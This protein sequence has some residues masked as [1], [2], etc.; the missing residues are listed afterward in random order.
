M[1][2]EVVTALVGLASALFGAGGGITAY[3][4]LRELGD[5]KEASEIE[6]LRDDVRRLVEGEA[7]CRREV[8]D[9]T[10]RLEA[11][12]HNHVS[13]LARWIKDGRKRITW[14][15]AKALLSIFAPLGL[16]RTDVIGRTFAELKEIDPGAAREIDLLDRQALR[17]P[18]SAA[19]GLVQLNLDLPVM[20]VVKV[21]GPGRDG[22]LVYEGYAYTPNRPEEEQRR[23]EARQ[24]EQRG[25]SVIA[26]SGAASGETDIVTPL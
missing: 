24:A 14:I 26:L 6:R 22:E 13:Y 11:F 9:L 4:R 2:G 19:S 18:G 17:L 21:A 10:E 20:C 1:A 7:R 12:E 25:A 3:V 5:K 8:A 15:N 23:G 16:S